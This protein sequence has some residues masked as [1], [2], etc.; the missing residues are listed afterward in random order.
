M[1]TYG[2]AGEWGI[3]NNEGCLERQLYGQHEVLS[4][5]N[6]YRPEEVVAPYP[7]CDCG[8]EGCE[9]PILNCECE[10]TE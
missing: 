5:L 8:E 9:C 7:M 4:A 10:E 2:A 1:D 6:R 3:F